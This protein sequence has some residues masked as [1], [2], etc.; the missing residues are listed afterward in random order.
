MTQ[1]DAQNTIDRVLDSKP[2]LKEAIERSHQQAKQVRY[3]ETIGGNYRRL[4]VVKS[5]D[6]S[7]VSRALRQAFNAIVQG[8]GAYCT[9]N[10]LIM[11]GDELQKHNLKAEMVLTVHDSIVVDCPPEEVSEVC[12]LMKYCFENLQ[13]PELLDLDVGNLRVPE[14]Y[15]LGNGKFRLPLKGACE[16]G[17]NYNDDVEYDK[18]DLA[19]FKSVTGFCKYQYTLIQLKE[20]LQAGIL[21]EDQYNGKLQQMEAVKPQFQAIGG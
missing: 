5:N 18:E 11:L 10:A 15:L 16:F 20:Y 6:K 7:K 9:N 2:Q 14:K 19:T 1:Q 21:T 8:S 4:D 3:V 13:V 12:D 17:L